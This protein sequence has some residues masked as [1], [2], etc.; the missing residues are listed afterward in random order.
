MA[1]SELLRLQ[2]LAAKYGDLQLKFWTSPNMPHWTIEL[3]NIADNGTLSDY[4]L[5]G[6][7]D[8]IIEAIE[9]AYANYY[10]EK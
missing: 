8:T 10:L 7:G 9:D 5:I 1:S 3:V 2:T 4:E 6:S